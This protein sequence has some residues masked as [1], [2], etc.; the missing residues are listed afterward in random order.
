MEVSFD[1]YMDKET[2]VY[3]N[4]GILFEPKKDGTPAICDNMYKYVGHYT[5]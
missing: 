1:G 3:I 4:N 5:K 2:V